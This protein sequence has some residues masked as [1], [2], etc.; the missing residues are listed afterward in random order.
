MQVGIKPT[1]LGNGF[2]YIRKLKSRLVVQLDSTSRD[3][4]IIG[5]AARSRPKNIKTLA[6]IINS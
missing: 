2:Y 5:F 4:D 6:K 1:N 3:A